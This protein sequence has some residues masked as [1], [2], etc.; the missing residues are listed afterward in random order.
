[1]MNLNANS[2]AQFKYKGFIKHQNLNMNLQIEYDHQ[3]R[4]NPDH[5][6]KRILSTPLKN[7]INS[8]I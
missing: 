3:I 5:K 2:I 4:I 8:E 1:M 6:E 7:I